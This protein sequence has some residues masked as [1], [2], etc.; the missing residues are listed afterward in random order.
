MLV[1]AAATVF[2]ATVGTST[3]G[4]YIESATGIRDGARTALVGPGAG[5]V[6]HRGHPDPRTYVGK[7]KLSEVKEAFEESDADV[8]LVDGELDPTQQRELENA[9]QARVVDRTQHLGRYAAERAEARPRAAAVVAL[10][11]EPERPV[12]AEQVAAVG[13]VPVSVEAHV[14]GAQRTVERSE[15]TGIAG[16]HPV[17]REREIFA[18]HAREDG[19]A[20]IGETMRNAV[21]VQPELVAALLA[22]R[23]INGARV[24]PEVEQFIVEAVA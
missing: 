16:A 3:S 12:L 13:A 11:I 6:Q 18:A 20:G 10:V 1:D 24:E 2:A 21:V 9:L 7:G 4:A 8:L 22:A 19:L 14:D 23:E 5:V 15:A 17:A